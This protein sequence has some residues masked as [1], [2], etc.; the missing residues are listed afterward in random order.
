M[1]RSV[2]LFRKQGIEVIPA[3]T[4]FKVTEL[5]WQNLTQ[6]SL[7]AQLI[8]FIPSST[9]LEWL[10]ATLKEYIGILVYRLRGWI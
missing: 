5:Q 4:D 9:N 10:T 7:E 8:N 6:P 3:P 2:A 1:P